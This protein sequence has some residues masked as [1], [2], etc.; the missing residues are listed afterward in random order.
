[1][2]W[3]SFC[4]PK[5]SAVC[6]AWWQNLDWLQHSK[7]ACGATLISLCGSKA[8]LLFLPDL[9]YFV[10]FCTSASYPSF[11]LGHAMMGPVFTNFNLR[12]RRSTASSWTDFR[13]SRSSGLAVTHL[14]YLQVYR[15]HSSFEIGCLASLSAAVSC[16]FY[17]WVSASPCSLSTG[18]LE[19]SWPGCASQNLPACFYVR[20]TCGL[21]FGQAAW[22]NPARWSRWLGPGWPVSVTSPCDYSE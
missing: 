15:L 20:Q 9:S 2:K 12:A 3:N 8:H 6:L 14:L 10:Y 1:M 18:A 13:F 4:A 11:R 7:S 19:S 21:D 5:E 22:S 17:P 16:H